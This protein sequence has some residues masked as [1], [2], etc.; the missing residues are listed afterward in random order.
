MLLAFGQFYG[1][2][3]VTWTWEGR[4]RRGRPRK[5]WRQ[6]VETGI[7]GSENSVADWMLVHVLGTKKLGKRERKA[8]CPL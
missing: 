6:T 2:H 5:T 4:R 1:L 3:T 8:L 7:G